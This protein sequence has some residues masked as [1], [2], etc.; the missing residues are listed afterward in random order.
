MACKMVHV[1]TDMQ[2]TTRIDRG[3]SWHAKVVHVATDC[4]KQ[5]AL[6][7]PQY[8]HEGKS[9]TRWRE[10]HRCDAMSLDANDSRRHP[11]KPWATLEKF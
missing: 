3:P 4:K 11:G 2:G 10:W 6:I 1:A 9:A 7:V 8:D 5:L